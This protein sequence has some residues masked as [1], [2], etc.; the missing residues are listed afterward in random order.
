MKNCRA[1]LFG[2]IDYIAAIGGYKFVDI[3]N[4]TINAYSGSTFEHY[5]KQVAGIYP[6]LERSKKMMPAE[7]FAQNTENAL[8][9]RLNQLYEKYPNYDSNRETILKNFMA[10]VYVAEL[11]EMIR[12][13]EPARYEAHKA[14]FQNK[15][16]AAQQQAAQQQA[17]AIVDAQQQIIKD[18]PLY[19]T[20]ATAEQQPARKSSI[21]PGIDFLKNLDDKQKK[22]M[23]IGAAALL[24]AFVL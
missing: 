24:A 8:A 2:N 14:L 22:Y 3:A 16:K 5:K 6:G 21:E 20:A 13:L 1:Q 23:A 9:H 7:V 17:A 12:F 15:T 19:N 4:K 18:A 11:G 10:S